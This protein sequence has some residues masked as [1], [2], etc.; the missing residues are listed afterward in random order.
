[1][2]TSCRQGPH[3]HAPSIEIDAATARRTMPTEELNYLAEWIIDF[4]ERTKRDRAPRDVARLRGVY[5]AV[6]G[7]PVRWGKSDRRAI[8]VRITAAILP[9]LRAARGRQRA[10][11]EEMLA[12]VL[13][14]ECEEPAFEAL[15]APWSPRLR[16]QLSGK[17]RSAGRVFALL[18]VNSGAFGRAPETPASRSGWHPQSSRSTAPLGRQW[19]KRSAISPAETN[20]KH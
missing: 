16:E 12:K 9:D 17:R 10:H 4:V 3:R 11:L 18:V 19:K 6:L 8:G 1:M 2:A 13:A 5:R 15:T 14:L 7:A 20:G